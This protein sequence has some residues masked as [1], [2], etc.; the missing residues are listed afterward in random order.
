[1]AGVRTHKHHS[2]KTTGHYLTSCNYLIKRRETFL[3]ENNLENILVVN[4]KSH[5]HN[6]AKPVYC[7]LKLLLIAVG[8]NPAA[9]RVNSER[10]EQCIWKKENVQQQRYIVI[11]YYKLVDE[12]TE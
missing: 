12:S 2:L 7:H 9:K 6:I 8:Q 1:M 10:T 4:Y 5:Y 11:N 3:N